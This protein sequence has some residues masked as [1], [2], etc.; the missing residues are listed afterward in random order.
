MSLCESIKIEAKQENRK[1]IYVLS[2][3]ITL[4]DTS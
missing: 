4:M 1:I 3:L 2:I